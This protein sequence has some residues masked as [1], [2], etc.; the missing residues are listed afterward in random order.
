MA[1]Y[2]NLINEM[3]Y[4]PDG[5]E[6]RRVMKKRSSLDVLGDTAVAISNHDQ[7]GSSS[8]AASG[9]LGSVDPR[10]MNPRSMDP[11]S[12]LDFLVSGDATH[13]RSQSITQMLANEYGN[14]ARKQ[15]MGTG[16]KPIDP[17][18]MDNLFDDQAKLAAA[19][20]GFPNNPPPRNDM[21]T[22]QRLQQ[23]NEEEDHALSNVEEYIKL[24]KYQTCL[25][26]QSISNM[27][28][29][30]TLMQQLNQVQ[31]HDTQQH[32]SMKMEEFQIYQEKQHQKHNQQ[33]RKREP[34]EPDPEPEP[35]DDELPLCT[36]AE[37]DTFEAS[38]DK[39]INTQTDIQKWDKK[40]GL[41]R[42][43]S[44]TMT[45]TT[46]S[47]KNLKKILDKQRTVLK[48]FKLLDDNVQ[49]PSKEVVKTEERD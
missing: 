22:L 12:S 14:S 44:A 16:V 48:E 46:R 7:M 42:S 40:M 38:M 33:I 21:M 18:Q 8:T 41:K 36:E 45:K 23:R 5:S 19:S 2:S 31:G 29:E 47:R 37:M 20:L 17:Y 27:Y 49:E 24:Q 32:D 43:H 3:G 10:S 28:D 6:Q 39:S 25:R 30:I 34:P 1:M 15:S 26:R 13:A 11:R 35:E 4:N 9:F